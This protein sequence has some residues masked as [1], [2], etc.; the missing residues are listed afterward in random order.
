MPL[1]PSNARSTV[2]RSPSS[3]R[4]ISFA[5]RWSSS[6][7]ST[8]IAIA[9]LPTYPARRQLGRGYLM[10]SRNRDRITSI[11]YESWRKIGNRLCLFNSILIL[12]GY[13]RDVSSNQELSAQE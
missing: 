11:F 6:I 8:L 13:H 4:E 5:R 12:T 7:I 10:L 2:K 9:S 1:L 3:T